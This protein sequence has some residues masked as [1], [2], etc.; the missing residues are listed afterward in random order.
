MAL[1]IATVTSRI[2]CTPKSTLQ[3]AKIMPK[4]KIILPNTVF[5]KKLLSAIII[6]QKVCREGIEQPFLQRHN[7][8]MLKRSNGREKLIALRITDKVINETSGT[9]IIRK[10][11][12]NLILNK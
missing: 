5:T 3:A 10:I 9:K 1:K 8:V 12:S 2:V 4:I 11:L 6:M 7:G